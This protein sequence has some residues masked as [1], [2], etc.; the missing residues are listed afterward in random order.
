MP[1]AATREWLRGSIGALDRCDVNA[2][3]IPLER[4]EALLR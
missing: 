4:L 2:L 3:T 1:P